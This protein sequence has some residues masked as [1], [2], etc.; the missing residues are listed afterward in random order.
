MSYKDKICALNDVI[1]LLSILKSEGKKIV[2]TN[3]CFDL[4]H[5]GHIFYLEKAKLLGDILIVGLNSDASVGRLKGEGRPIKKIEN[6]LAVLAGLASVDLV[7][8]FEEDT[9]KNLIEQLKPDI[10]VKGG[11]YKK[12]N[13]VGAEFIL[14]NGGKVE[15]IDFVQGYSSSFIIRKMESD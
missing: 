8:V 2:F 5:K 14:E 11:D 4:L 13:I 3:G 9:P 12:E 6:R 15:I 7:V 10:L 1:A